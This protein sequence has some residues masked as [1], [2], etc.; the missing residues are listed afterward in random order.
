MAQYEFGCQIP[1]WHW[2]WDVSQLRDWAQGVDALGCDFITMADHI[3]YA[4][5]RPDRPQS[6]AYTDDVHQHEVMTLMAWLSEVTEQIALQPNVLVLAQREPVL[7]AKQAAEIDVLSNGRLRLGIGV[8]WQWQEFEAL[9]VNIKQRPSRTEEYIKVLRACWTEEP[10]SF[11]GKY[12]QIDRM[13]MMPKPVTPGGPPILF[14]GLS[15]AAIERAAR[16]GDGWVA[17]VHTDVDRLLPRVRLMQDQLR[18]N[19]RDLDSFPIQW[20]PPLNENADEVLRQM[21]AAR[22]AGVTRM[23]CGMPNYDREGIMPVDDVLRIIES[24]RRQVWPEIVSS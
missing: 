4:Y 20:Q 5:S 11:S 16:I 24:T 23:G 15:Q 3:L 13:S 14:G 1:A 6:G 21:T 10:I 8:G 22:D 9:G 19:G 2:H 18:A 12:V 7:V 17:T